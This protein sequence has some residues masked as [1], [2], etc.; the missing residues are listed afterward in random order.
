M[1]FVFTYYAA[2]FLRK[3]LEDVKLSQTLWG[4]FSEREHCFSLA[5]LTVFDLGQQN[6]LPSYKHACIFSPPAESI[7]LSL[8]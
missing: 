3:S 1:P 2:V 7:F 6:H 5:Y 8:L 4:L